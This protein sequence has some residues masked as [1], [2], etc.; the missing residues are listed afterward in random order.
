[1]REVHRAGLFGRG[2]AT[3]GID[4]FHRLLSQVMTQS[5]YR[6]AHR[7]FWICD[8]GSSHSGHASVQRIQGAF[9]NVVP[10]HG[11]VHASWLNQI[12]I[13]YSIPHLPPSAGHAVDIGW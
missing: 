11:P 6:E 4:P 12:E 8:N 1:M 7:V 13:Y 3:T 10:V 5:R 2:E 9:P